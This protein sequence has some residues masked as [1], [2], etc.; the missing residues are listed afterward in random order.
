MVFKGKYEFL[1]KQDTAEPDMFDLDT[2]EPVPSEWI[3][4]QI[5]QIPTYDEWLIAEFT[6]WVHET[7]SPH[8]RFNPMEAS[9]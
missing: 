9:E 4:S 5:Y 1:L 6:F 7:S 2:I 3:K 8:N